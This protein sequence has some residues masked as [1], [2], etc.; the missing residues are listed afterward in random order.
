V[1]PGLEH[2]GPS[3]LGNDY[4]Y[5][6]TMQPTALWFHD[7]ALGMTRINIY[8]G[9]AGF[10]LIRGKGDTGGSDKGLGLPAGDRELELLIADRM[11]DTNGQLIFPDDSEGIGLN[12]TPPNPSVHPYWIPEYFGDVIVV[13]GMAWPKMTVKPLRYRFRILNGSNARFYNLRLV[14]D[15]QEGKGANGEH[16]PTK[17]PVPTFWVIGI[18]GGLLD[19]PVETRELLIAPPERYDLIIDFGAFAGRKLEMTNDANA[20]FPGG[21]PVAPTPMVR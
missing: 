6:N 9:L 4:T 11:F 12:G 20:P 16:R 8:S 15:A 10:Y 3:F 14:A 2:T 1:D 18:D 19:E 17:D 13:N 7:H 21:D 5:V